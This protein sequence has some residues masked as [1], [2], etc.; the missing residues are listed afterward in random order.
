MIIDF[1]FRVKEPYQKR[2]IGIWPCSRGP[3]WYVKMVGGGWYRD[4]ID[5]SIN[6]RKRRRE[7]RDLGGDE[8]GIVCLHFLFPFFCGT[9]R[10]GLLW[11]GVR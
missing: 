3:L 7:Q 10:V 11:S 1:C 9:T 8:K 5:S 4:A 2:E 6:E